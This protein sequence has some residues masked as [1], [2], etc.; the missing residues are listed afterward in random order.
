MHSEWE[1]DI[2]ADVFDS[3]ESDTAFAKVAMRCERWEVIR[4]SAE[5]LRPGPGDGQDGPELWLPRLPLLEVR[6]T[7]I[8]D[9][10]LLYGDTVPT[11]TLALVTISSMF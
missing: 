4:S 5:W 7:S 1:P 9:G 10:R 11:F 6:D 8:A 3:F 2:V